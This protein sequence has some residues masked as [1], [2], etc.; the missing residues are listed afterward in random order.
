MEKL[1]DKNNKEPLAFSYPANI[2]GR[3]EVLTVVG[4]A[5]GYHVFISGNPVVKIKLNETNHSWFISDGELPELN[6]AKE[7]GQRI[8]AQYF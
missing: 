7:I 3:D 2:N 4:E 6:L 8:E 1:K 5:D